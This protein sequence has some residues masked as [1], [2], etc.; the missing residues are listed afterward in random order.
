MS[1]IRRLLIAALW[2]VCVFMVVVTMPYTLSGGEWGVL[3]FVMFVAGAPIGTV[4]INWVIEGN[5]QFYFN[6]PGAKRERVVNDSTG[7]GISVIPDNFQQ[8]EI[9][10]INIDRWR[11]VFTIFKWSAI[12]HACVVVANSM[13][14][15][16]GD[17]APPS[18]ALYYIGLLVRWLSGTVFWG[19]ILSVLWFVSS[20]FSTIKQR[21]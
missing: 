17:I 9:R 18:E 4:L 13:F 16:R 5:F 8:R 10:S 7:E 2:C 11:P 1:V 15:I 3:M 19:V 14:G 20:W 12:V 21:R 6:S